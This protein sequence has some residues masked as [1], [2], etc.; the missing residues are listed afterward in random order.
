MQM[1]SGYPFRQKRPLAGLEAQLVAKFVAVCET[2]IQ[3]QPQAINVW[4]LHLGETLGPTAKRGRIW[5]LRY[6]RAAAV[7]TSYG[8]HL[9][10]VALEWK[11]NAKNGKEWAK[12]RQRTQI[13]AQNLGEVPGLVF[14]KGKIALTV[15]IWL[16]FNSQGKTGTQLLCQLFS[17]P[18]TKR[19]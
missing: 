8:N 15:D 4:K 16:K 13:R 17:S 2:P 7:I 12:K 19:F 1:L 9:P 10:R 11:T 18:Q 5:G 14:V 6:R 3:V